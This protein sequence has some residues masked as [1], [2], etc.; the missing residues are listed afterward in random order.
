MIAKV[1]YNVDKSY[2]QTDAILKCLEKKHIL[3]CLLFNLDRKS[4]EFLIEQNKLRPDISN[5]L[6]QSLWT[7]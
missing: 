2:V 1:V 7:P 3:K 5:T 6:E 4:S